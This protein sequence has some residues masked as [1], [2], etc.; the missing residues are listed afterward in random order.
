MDMHAKKITNAPSDQSSTTL[1][2]KGDV[3]EVRSVGEVLAT[4]DGSGALEGLPFM[5]E[6]LEFCGK[7]FRIARR[8]EKT[9]VDGHPEAFREFKNNNVVLLE[10]L[11]CSG[12]AHGGCQR[13][14]M[15]FWKEQWLRKV[16]KN[17]GTATVAEMGKHRPLP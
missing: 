11:R 14:C 12:K 16:A 13:G 15:L 1:F 7:T 17:E 6:M 5:P 2:R 10:E 8:A 3:V 9:C 4:L